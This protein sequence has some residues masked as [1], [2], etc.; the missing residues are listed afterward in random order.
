M[1]VPHAQYLK[2]QTSCEMP[3][4]RPLLRTPN[5]AL[6]TRP[7]RFLP[8]FLQGWDYSGRSGGVQHAN[9]TSSS[10]LPFR[11]GA[12][13]QTIRSGPVPTKLAHSIQGFSHL[14]WRAPL[15]ALAH[16]KCSVSSHHGYQ[17]PIVTSSIP[18]LE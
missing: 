1:R 15:L 9:A 3:H 5:C 4:P 11:I 10:E 7:R 8:L 12:S 17:Y 14:K 6:L 13:R 2:A 18:S 16:P